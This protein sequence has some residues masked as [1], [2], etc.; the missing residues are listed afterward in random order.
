MSKLIVANWKMNGNINKIKA[1][2]IT[3]AK[4]LSTN[5]S[6]VVLAIPTLYLYEASQ[7]CKEFNVKFKLACQDIS[8]FS[9]FGAYT[10]EISA[11]MMKE[12]NVSYVIVGHSERRAYLNES[13]STLLGKI[14]NALL[15]EITPIFCIGE[16]IT[17][18]NKGGY[19][20]FLIQQLELLT[21]IKTP[22]SSLVIAYEPIWAIGTGVIP[23]L[24][25]ISEISKLI[26]AFV[27]NYLPHAKITALYGGSVSS[28]N[29]QAILDILDVG[30]VLVGGASLVVDDFSKICLY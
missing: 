24:E 29:A 15:N 6:T 9:N 16:D 17:T 13:G 11:T 25:Q 20:E 8:Q 27:Q 7:I 28:K 5:Q 22:F 30:G 14:E 26:H 2:L 10:G 23:T 18:R 21:Q 4:T 1:D 12:T 3:Y 19:A